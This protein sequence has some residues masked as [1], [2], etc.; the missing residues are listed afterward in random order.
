M[1]RDCKLILEITDHTRNWIAKI[2]VNDKSL[3]HQARYG[4]KRYQRLTFS[5][6]KGNRVQ[7]TIF[8]SDISLFQHTFSP[9]KSYYV[10]DACVNPIDPKYRY[11]SNNYQWIINNRTRVEDVEENEEDVS[12]EIY[13]FV[14]FNDLNAHMNSDTNRFCCYCLGCLTNENG[15]IRHN[16]SSRNYSY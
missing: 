3:T 13:K 8:D 5:D 4:T 16:Y 7:A 10:S 12:E 15:K 1:P 14:P 2:Q 6:S 9:M 11:V